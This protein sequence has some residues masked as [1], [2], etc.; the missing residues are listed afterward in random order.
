MCLAFLC[1][2]LN[3]ITVAMSDIGLISMSIAGSNVAVSSGPV[4]FEGFKTGSFEERERETTYSMIIKHRF[5]HLFTHS[6]I[7]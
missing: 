2:L 6:F 4:K 7:Q 5:I 3:L 1:N